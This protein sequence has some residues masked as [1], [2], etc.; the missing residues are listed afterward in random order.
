MIIIVQSGKIRLVSTVT[1]I[2]AIHE[3]HV[4]QLVGRLVAFRTSLLITPLALNG[5]KIPLLL[6]IRSF[7][8]G[9][10]WKILLHTGNSG[11]SWLPSMW[12]WL[13]HPG[14]AS[15]TLICRCHGNDDDDDDDDDDDNDDD[16]VGRAVKEFLHRE[17]IHSTTV[18]L[19]YH[20]DQR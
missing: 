7:R 5:R 18:Q 3:F 9:F 19:E 8:R 16:K 17:G 11:R 2:V 20:S 14:K 1:G 13:H 12:S 15:L 6:M 10:D 4:W